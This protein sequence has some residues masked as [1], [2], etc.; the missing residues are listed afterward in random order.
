MLSEVDV[1]IIGS[2]GVPTAFIIPPLAT[3]K[4]EAKD[5]VPGDPF[6]IVPSWIVKVTPASTTTFWFN[7]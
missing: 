4:A 5:P 6:I 2:E 3:I 7:L 1:K